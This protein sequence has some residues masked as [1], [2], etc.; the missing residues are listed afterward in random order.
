MKRKV[1]LNLIFNIVSIVLSFAL[2]IVIPRLVIVSFGSEI[3]GLIS[4]VGQIFSYVGLMEA[5]IGATALQA[6][7]SP[8]AHKDRYAVNRILSAS[9]RYYKKIGVI[10]VICVVIVA[11]IYPHVIETG[12]DIWTVVGVVVFSGLGNAIN[13]LL[14]QNYVV[15]LSAEGK[16]YV[17]TALGMMVNI[18]TSVTK[19]VLLL[20]GYNVVVVTGAQFF[21]TLLR[22]LLLRVYMYACKEYE[23]IDLSVEPN[24]AALSKQRSV[25][26]QQVSYFV[27]SNTDI[28]ILTAFCDLKTVSVYTVYSMVVGVLESLLGAVTNSTVFAFGQLYSRDFDRFKKSFTTFD[29]L[30]MTLLFALYTVMYLCI[31][32]FMRLYTAGISDANYVDQKLALLFVLMKFATT[33]RSQGQN[34]VN[35]AGK[36]RETQRSAILEAAMNLAI[37]LVAVQWIGIYGVVLGSVVSTLYRGFS[38]TW[39]SNKHILHYTSRENMKKYMRW[40][41][42]MLCFVIISAFGT[43]YIRMYSSYFELVIAASVITI[44][45]IVTYFGILFAFDGQLR[46]EVILQVKKKVVK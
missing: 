19:V 30:Y 46:K 5:G 3:N 41:V 1:G 7:Y 4:S 11:L 35:F 38:I 34:C 43:K 17:T 29:S 25:M 37:S 31:V 2:G 45:L 24:T 20:L 32:P 33:L 12:I 26:I 27:Y 18:G 9:H 28:L 39:Y 21:I 13:F 23:W 16:G 42:N 6:L 8:I 44:I 36:F 14:Q 22:I 10:Y 40:T 15:L